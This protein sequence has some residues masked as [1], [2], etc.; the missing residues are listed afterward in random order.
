MC[1]NSSKTTNTNTNSAANSATNSLHQ[2]NYGTNTVTNTGQNSVSNTAQNYGQNTSSSLCKTS[3]LIIRRILH[4][5]TIKIQII[6]AQTLRTTPEQITRITHAQT[7]PSALAQQYLAQGTA[8]LSS[9]ISQY[10]N[11]YQQQVINSTMAQLQNQFGQQQ[12]Q[13]I[14]NAASQNALGGDRSAIAQAALA[15]QQ[16]LVSGSTLSSL[17][18]QNYQQALQ[19]AQ[20]QAGIYMQAANA[21]GTQTTGQ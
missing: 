6:P 14:G 9:Q 15:G 1:F 18:A 5:I 11:P 13:I 7:G 8:P 19:A 12:Q 21:A 3:L 2:Q 20:A 10:Y 16:D 17:N 4:L